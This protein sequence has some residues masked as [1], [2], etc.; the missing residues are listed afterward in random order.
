[1]AWYWGFQARRVQSSEFVP[2]PTVLYW[3]YMTQM[4]SVLPAERFWLFST[5]MSLK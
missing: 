3:N 5:N 1:M 4:L 2:P